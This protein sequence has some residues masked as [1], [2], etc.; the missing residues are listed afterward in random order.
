M[1][2]DTLCLGLLS[3][4]P[5][6]GYEIKQMFEGTLSDF[7]SLSF[8]TIYPTL[9]K[10]QDEKYVSCKQ[11][12]QSKKP[13]KK[14]YT[15][16][17]KGKDLMKDNLLGDASAYIRSGNFGDQIKSE[18]FL[19][20]LFAKYLPQETLDTVLNERVLFLRQKLEQFKY[21]GPVPSDLQ[22]LRNEKSVAFI[23]GLATAL[24]ESG[25]NYMEKNRGKLN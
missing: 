25:L 19:L 7:Y 3:L 13:D 23:R 15:I 14:V 6:S 24:I 17:K 9:N 16:T 20:L 11:L 21:D 1:Q 4:G 12:S 22:A 10:L 18:F 8:G 5:R 2:K